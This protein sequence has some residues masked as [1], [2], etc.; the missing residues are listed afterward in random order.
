[1]EGRPVSEARLLNCVLQECPFVTL[2]IV[3]RVGWLRKGLCQDGLSR[4]L[5]E[6]LQVNA[7][8]Q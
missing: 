2:N 4:I 1:M 7:K 8:G 6:E 3:L 5:E